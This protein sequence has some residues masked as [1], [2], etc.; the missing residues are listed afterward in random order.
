MSYDHYRFRRKVQEYDLNGWLVIDS[1]LIDSKTG[2][3]PTDAAVLSAFAHN[4]A[5]GICLK[6]RLDF[7]AEVRSLGL[8]LGAMIH[9]YDHDVVYV[10]NLGDYEAQKPN[11]EEYGLM[12]K[13]MK[14]LYEV[15]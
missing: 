8:P 4:E 12:I 2:A 14:R 3:I 7:S 15:D 6:Y 5:T 11:P 13:D 1:T 10:I 9:R